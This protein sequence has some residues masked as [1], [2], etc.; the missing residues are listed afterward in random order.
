[1]KVTCGTCDKTYDDAECVTICPHWIVSREDL[2]RKDAAMKLLGK[3]VRFRNDTE[4]DYPVDSVSWNGLVK[5]KGY[6]LQFVQFGPH[7]F[8]VEE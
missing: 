5:L 8:V 2:D 1:M 7:M 6:P 3:K 4:V